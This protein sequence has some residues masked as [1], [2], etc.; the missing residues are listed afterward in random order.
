MAGPRARDR[1][2]HVPKTPAKDRRAV[3]S[4]AFSPD[5]KTLATGSADQT[6]RLWDVASHQQSLALTGHTDAVNSLKFSLNGATL[7]SGSADDTVRLWDVATHRFIGPPLAGHADEVTSVAFSP[8][9]QA[10]VPTPRCGCGMSHPW[11]GRRSTH[12]S[13][14]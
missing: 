14:R 6:V 4:V 11:A 1:L 10:A 3:Y 12:R 2:R 13:H 5:G 7:A 9:W 8:H